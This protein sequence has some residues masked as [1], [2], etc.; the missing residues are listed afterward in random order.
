VGCA[1]INIRASRARMMTINRWINGVSDK[2]PM[3]DVE[4]SHPTHGVAVTSRSGPPA[5]RVRFQ[6]DCCA[7]WSA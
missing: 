5:P 6:R 7:V 1:R 3:R 2:D 4:G